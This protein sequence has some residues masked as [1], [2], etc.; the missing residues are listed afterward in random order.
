MC[1]QNP[2]HFWWW[3]RLFLSIKK[4]KKKTGANQFRGNKSPK[5]F[6]SNIPHL[7][8]FVRISS[9]CKLPNQ[10]WKNTEV[11]QSSHYVSNSY[12]SLNEIP[13]AT[14]L[15][16]KLQSSWPSS[17]LLFSIYKDCWSS[18]F[19]WC[20]IFP[21]VNSNFPQCIIRHFSDAA[22]T[23]AKNVCSSKPHRIKKNR[24]Y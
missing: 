3:L 15:V 7:N 4:K 6:L 11:N 13:K 2:C 8:P 5:T 12:C 23:Y 20:G 18:L 24:K 22:Y 9:K 19:W 1:S 17:W 14:E 10:G 16:K 21:F